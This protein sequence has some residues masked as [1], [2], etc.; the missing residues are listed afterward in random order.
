MRREDRRRQYPVIL[1]FDSRPPLTSLCLSPAPVPVTA[2]STAIL[3]TRTAPMPTH[4][5]I[6]N[7]VRAMVLSGSSRRRGM[8]CLSQFIMESEQSIFQ[9]LIAPH[10]Q[11]ATRICARRLA[12]GA[13]SIPPPPR[14]LSR[15]GSPRNQV[16]GE[17]SLPTILTAAGMVKLCGLPGNRGL[18]LIGLDVAPTK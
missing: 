18:P 10:L 11:P 14:D 3:T 7:S 4:P 1:S 2:L 13:T 8:W 5:R 9:N 16:P 6:I 12:T 17:E 15:H